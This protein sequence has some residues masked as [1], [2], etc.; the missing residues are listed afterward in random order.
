MGDD[1]HAAAEV[2]EEVLQNAQGL[3]VQ[4]VRG[5][6]QQQHVRGLDQHPAQRQP[7]PFS[8]GKFRQRA[9]LLCGGEQK[10][11]QQLR[12]C[13]LFATE[14]DPAGGLL[15]EVDHLPLQALALGERFGVLIEVADVHGFPEFKGSARGLAPAGNQIQQGRLAAAVGT[16]DSDPILRA[17]AVAEVL[18]QRAAVLLPIGGDADRFGFDHHLADAT[19][20]AGHLQ[21]VAGLQRLLLPHRL[22][23]LQAGFLFGAPSLGALAQPGQFPSQHA[24]E[25]GGRGR[26]R[27]LFLSLVLQVGAVVPLIGAGLAPIHLHHAA[28]H[29]V[30]HVTVMGHQHQGP[31]VSV[32]PVLQPFH[33]RGIQMVGG[34]IEQQYIRTGH[35]C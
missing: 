27:G 26:F 28:G 30:Q 12:G 35:Q 33:G 23:A 16:D 10:P 29:P 31:W 15:D 14:V 7:S 21:L 3:H 22:D 5:L 2:F 1:D 20:H 17:E 19:A 32:Q 25:L 18:E 34:F 6:I 24:F 9:V 4:I 13:D 11:F 8:P